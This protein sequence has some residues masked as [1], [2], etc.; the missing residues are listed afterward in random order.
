MRQTAGGGHG[1]RAFVVD[2][3]IGLLVMVA[4]AA[5]INGS[6]EAHARK[7]GLVAYAFAVGI[8]A[9]LLVRRK[10]PV[11][12]LVG[13]LLLLFGYYLLGYSAIGVAVP[14]AAAL[15]SAAEYGRL[16]L[17]IGAA[18]FL[19]IGSSA[20]RV[21][22][23]DDPAY[24]F[25][26]E[27]VSN[28]A[29]LAATIALADSVRSRRKWRAELELRMAEA[30]R[31][32]EREQA[33]RLEQER[34]RVARDLH[35]VLTH[36]ISVI[37]LHTDVAREVLRT[38]PD[39][40]EDSLR[41]V[42]AASSDAVRGLQSTLDLLRMRGG[43]GSEP[44]DRHPVGGL[45]RLDAIVRSATDAGLDVSVRTEGQPRPLPVAVDTAAYWIVQE[46][47]TN[48]LRHAGARHVSVELRYGPDE[49]AVRIA[50]DGR[51]ERGGRARDGWGIVGMRERA[52]LV[53]GQLRA[54]GNGA[55][56]F[57][58]QALLPLGERR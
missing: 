57:V 50:D 5:A 34:L 48:V 55:G 7:P 9:V 49:L 42:R 58:V 41:A 12:T 30:E 45:D 46:S 24:L 10:Y 11:V 38:D 16:R 40:A 19:V 1:R 27:L 28:V 36:T 29:L 26:Y 21:L 3:A 31:E 32:R 13:T 14:A 4:V 35:D 47:L 54:G 20:Y 17:A 2:G 18:V 39:T 8:G 53:G 23:G 33:R 37:S 15:Y 52:G 22:E 51:G 6:L 44:A 56:G 25:G 43:D